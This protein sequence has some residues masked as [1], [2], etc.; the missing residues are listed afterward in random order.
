MI[1]DLIIN[2]FLAIPFLLLSGLSAF[3]FNLELPANMFEILN[4]L[5]VGVS[6]V[7]PVVR[8]LPIFYSIIGIA[9][10]KALWSVVIRIK[11]FIPTMGS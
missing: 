5:L 3:D 9:T 10:F 6:Y 4:D 8:L 2:V 7:V 1:T 11:S